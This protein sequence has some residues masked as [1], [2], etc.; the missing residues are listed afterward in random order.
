MKT[1]VLLTGVSILFT[2]NIKAQKSDVEGGK[3]NVKFN[4]LSPILSSASFQI[5]RALNKNISFSMGIRYTYDPSWVLPLFNIDYNDLDVVNENVDAINS[6]SFNGWSFTPEL[7]IYTGKADARKNM[8]GFYFSP[9]FRYSIF[10]AHVDG[11]HADNHGVL[12][13]SDYNHHIIY[14]AKFYAWGAG[15]MIGKQWLIGEHISIDWQILGL[16]FGKAKA[17]GYL[18]D[19]AFAYPDMEDGPEMEPTEPLPMGSVI[20]SYI[21]GQQWKFNA[22]GPNLGVRT[23]LCIGIVF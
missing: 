1:A 18:D 5:E 19:P 22:K 7:R 12:P 2:G 11:N 3:N 10:H 17:N 4:V 13:P 23:G 15:L 21:E 9:Y 8:Q 6:K 20:N 14:D 16:H